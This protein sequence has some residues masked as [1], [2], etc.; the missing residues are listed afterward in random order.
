M[1]VTGPISTGRAL[2]M[3]VLQG[4]TELFP[5]SSLGHA[6]IFPHLVGWNL[7]QESPAFLPFLVA[8]HLGT[9][10]A[11]LIY[12]RSDWLALLTSLAPRSRSPLAGENRHLFWLLILGTVPAGLLGVLFERRLATLFGRY[13]VVALFLA[14][15]GLLLQVGEWLRRQDRSLSLSQLGPRQALAI[16]A[17]QAIALLPG[18][19]RAGASMVG[20]LMVGL[21]HESAARLSFLLSTPVILAA[22]VLELPKLMA[23]GLRSSL[24]PAL[25]GGLVAGVVAYLSTAFLMR[26]FNRNDVNALF[27]FGVYCFVA[28]VVALLVA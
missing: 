24:G 27:P 22:A 14:L 1:D 11:L 5:I 16:G 19:S 9:A 8:L 25:M 26:Y 28:G 21:T 18:F 17:T 3:A 2:V 15:N 12:F 20:G 7:D 10:V 13:Q 23:P 6:V 4:I